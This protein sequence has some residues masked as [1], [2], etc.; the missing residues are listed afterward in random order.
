[1]VP[2]IRLFGLFKFALRWIPKRVVLQLNEEGP[3]V[4]TIYSP[5]SHVDENRVALHPS[6]Q[7][8]KVEVRI[9]PVILFAP[10]ILFPTLHL[11]AGGSCNEWGE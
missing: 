5:Q 3:T 10:R 11:G 6:P 2:D 7:K 4:D 8:C 9:F 1:M